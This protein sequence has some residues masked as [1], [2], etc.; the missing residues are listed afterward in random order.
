MIE[1]LYIIL[2]CSI[3]L[4]FNTRTVT[5]YRWVLII[6]MI[7]L[8][9]VYKNKISS[10]RTETFTDDTEVDVENVLNLYEDPIELLP[11]QAHLAFYISC[12]SKKFIENQSIYNH[13]TGKKTALLEESVK[14]HIP[15]DYIQ[16]EGFFIKSK[17]YLPKPNHLIQSFDK[18]SLIFKLR[19]PYKRITTPTSISLIKFG[20][21]NVCEGRLDCPN[22]SIDA[23]TRPLNSTH[24]GYFEILFQFDGSEGQLNPNI[25]VRI[26]SQEWIYTYQNDTD[27]NDKLFMDDLEHVFSFVKDGQNFTLYLDEMV[28][29]LK[30]T[31]KN[32]IVSSLN[33]F[34]DGATD[35]ELSTINNTLINYNNEGDSVKFI[36]ASIII[37]RFTSLSASN[38]SEIVNFYKRIK[39]DLEPNKIRL[40]SIRS[41]N[42]QKNTLPAG[43]EEACRYVDTTNMSEILKDRK[44]LNSI[45]AE[46][47]KDESDLKMCSLLNTSN[48]NLLSPN[49]CE[50]DTRSATSKTLTKVPIDDIRLKKR[51]DTNE[52]TNTTSEL[53]HLINT[54]MNENQTVNLD[55]INT[56]RQLDTV[57]TDA[58]ATTSD[59]YNTLLASKTDTTPVQIGKE[60]PEDIINIDKDEILEKN[61]YRHIINNHKMNNIN[62]KKNDWSF[63]N[64]FT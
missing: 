60:K 37:Y 1:L 3:F 15:T 45:I 38:I 23:E 47:D 33:I 46:C 9:G 44:C 56:M 29:L 63:M 21:N 8:V 52:H 11:Q 49:E 4:I 40:E 12:Y 17:M 30:T 5:H 22:P 61:A 43:S 35:I 27:Y 24:T 41:E 2:L 6:S 51:I 13:V 42:Q 53:K 19:F 64:L 36:L 16:T 54:M 28:I 18:F 26:G 57:T 7:A 48:I 62:E 34:Y 59:V 58:T 10:N 20:T 50:D 25:I 32:E 39:E 31:Q 14:L 55:S